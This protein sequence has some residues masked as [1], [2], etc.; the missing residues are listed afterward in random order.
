MQA[1][2]VPL[3]A[4]I[5]HTTCHLL[6]GSAELAVSGLTADSRAVT[7][8][9][10]FAAI[11]GVKAD[12]RAFI[13]AALKAGATALLVPDGTPLAD[14]PRDI[15]VIAA[16]QPRL[17]LAQMAAAFFGDQPRVITAVT[18][19]NGK[20]STA[21]FTR[22]MW[23]LLGYPAASLGTLGL[24][25]PGLRI[26]GHA[27]TPD[28]V[29]LHHLLADVADQGTTHL[30]MEASSHGLDQFRLDG[31]LLTAAAVTNI[32]RDHMDYH[33]TFEAYLAAKE[34]LVTELLPSGHT[35]VLNAD[36]PEFSTLKKA[37]E[38][39]GRR[40]VSYGF[41]G[42]EL[43]IVHRTPT[44]SGQTLEL[45]I[46][47]RTF[48]VPLPLAGSFQ[49]SNALAALGLVLASGA[50][51]EPAVATLGHLHGV[52]GRLEKVG[53]RN[54]ASVFVDY[55]HTPDALDVV[56]N[57]LR[58]HAHGRLIVVFGCGGDRDTGK[59]PQMGEIAAR[60]ADHVIVTDDN[61]RSEDPALIRHAI[62]DACPG[63]ENIGDRHEAIAHATDMLA[64][65]DI[66]LIAGKGHESG[67]IVGS[68]IIPFDDRVVARAAL[69]GATGA[70]LSQAVLQD[71]G[72][73]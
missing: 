72:A 42:E 52:P 53:E 15:T 9:M 17:A 38:Q 47:G 51:L 43:R 2:K 19:T 22:Q 67:Q 32:T 41:A 39:A 4:V 37:A 69:Q 45:R 36:V 14:I 12:G 25:G 23:T 66:L 58:P 28:P 73:A 5:A 68:Q 49:A 30:C 6:S 27:T 20:T 29:S 48:S 3:S 44:I 50:E 46:H 24:S 60:L 13:P 63:A 65:G 31:V 57:A 11:P 35:A 59:R 7:P 70:E 16:A 8:G 56:L 1:V 71:G 33:H 40:V 26:A 61:P 21:V 34:R 64:D 54:G 18:G 55:A 10:L 62:L